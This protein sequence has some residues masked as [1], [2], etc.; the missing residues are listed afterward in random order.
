MEKLA[1]KLIIQRLQRQILDLE[2]FKT[3]SKQQ[4]SKIG[5][6]P[7]EQHF[8]NQVFPTGTIHEFISTAP[9]NTACTSAFIF[10]LLS[11]LQQ[12][13]GIYVWIGK[14]KQLF[15]PGLTFFGIPPHHI[16]FINLVKPKDILWATEEA[17]K[18]K[19]LSGVISEVEGIN[20]AQSQRLQLTVEKSKVT[21]FILRT[22]PENIT[23]T[24]C[25]ARWKIT[26]QAS[27]NTENI[28][29]VGFA[30]WQVELL[31]V[32]NGSTAN[33]TVAWRNQQ[34]YVNEQNNSAP[35]LSQAI[36]S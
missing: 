16:I 11:K 9:E 29:G 23:A 28:P 17:L 21:G 15:T 1:Q 24:A 3:N 22:Q 36:G 27:E 26:P 6:A 12:Q 20:F 25:A 2:G 18:C 33:F 35:F 34:F 7:I 5:F 10:G 30:N 31:K 14:Q 19:S 4:N 32:R 8:P 13:N